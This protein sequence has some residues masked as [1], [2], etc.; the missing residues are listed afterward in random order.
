MVH[1]VYRYF[2]KIPNSDQI[3]EWKSKRLSDER[4][5]PH[6]TFNNSLSPAINR[7]NIKLQVKIDGSCLKQEKVAFAHNK[8]V[9]IHIVYEINLWSNILGIG[10][11]LGN[12]LLELIS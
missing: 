11:A 7:I 8:V 12:C 2:K 4:S 6:A 10:F 9:N 5:K 3:S 1:P